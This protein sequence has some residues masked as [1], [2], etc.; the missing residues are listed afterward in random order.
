MRLALFA[1]FLFC[2]PALPADLLSDALQT[3]PANTQ[4]L[5][6]DN[7]AALRRL[8]NYNELRKQYTSD[9]LKR[10]KSTL[11]E[12]NIAEEQLSEVVTASGP[13]VFFGL[14]VGNFNASAAE[15]QAAAHHLTPSSLQDG[16]AFCS[17]E[18]VC[19]LFPKGENGRAA[20]GPVDQLRLM[21]EVHAGRA[22]NVRSNPNFAALLAKMDLTTPIVGLAPGSEIG[23]LTKNVMPPSLD[24]SSWYSSVESFGYSIRTDT[25]A[26]LTVELL[27]TS[28]TRG[29]LVGNALNTAAAVQRMA[30]AMSM[31]N[32]FPVSNL[33][34]TSSGRMVSFRFDA[35]LRS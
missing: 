28:A 33:R 7:L 1:F 13:N 6:Y 17:K 22:P 18:N 14:I 30:A 34:A 25:Q 12:L 29:R 11:L 27:C 5:E 2:L 15:Q 21:A 23:Q 8:P 19:V 3:F 10:V 20:F 26:H 9:A 4:S 31:G 24:L 32:A 16:Q 35:K